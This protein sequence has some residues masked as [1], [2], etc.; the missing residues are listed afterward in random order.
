MPTASAPA[1]TIRWLDPSLPVPD[2]Q[3]IWQYGTSTGSGT[4]ARG[5][6]STSTPHSIT[7]V[8][9]QTIKSDILTVYDHPYGQLAGHARRAATPTSCRAVAKLGSTSDAQ[10]VA[11]LDIN[12]LA[13]TDTTFLAESGD[14]AWIAFGEGNTGGAGRIMMV[15]DPCWRR[16]WILL[17]RRRGH[18]PHRQRER[19]SLRRGRRQHRHDAGRTRHESYFAAIQQSLPPTSAREI[20]LLRQRC[21]RRLPSGCEW[22]RDRHRPIALHSSVRRA[23]TSR[24]STSRT[25]CN[26]GRLTLKSNLYGPLRASRPVRRRSTGHGPQAVRSL[27]RGT[28]RHRSHRRRHQAGSVEATSDLIHDPPAREQCSRAGGVL[29]PGAVSL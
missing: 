5:C 15:N 20:R 1:G 19:K 16:S 22:Q 4:R 7:Q 21:R 25:S 27:E 26:R 17:A 2:P 18:G 8:H 9:R 11:N 12:S 3:Q 10:L 14:H 28:R 24:S 13:L 6:C 29:T 23:A